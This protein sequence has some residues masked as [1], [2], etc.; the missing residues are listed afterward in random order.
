MKS[1]TGLSLLFFLASFQLSL[2]AEPGVE[3]EKDRVT[4]QNGDAIRAVIVPSMGGELSGLSMRFDGD[5]HELLYRALDYEKRPGWRGKAPLLWPATGISVIKKSGEAGYLLDG[6]PYDMP[7]HGFARSSSWQV[8]GTE[9]TTEFA[10]LTL[11]LHDDANTRRFYPFGF[12]LQVEYRLDNEKLRLLYRVDADPGNDRDMPFSIGNHI[13]FR[14][15]LIPGS[16]PGDLRFENELPDLLL[17]GEDKAFSG[18]VEPSPYTG[19]H[20]LAS[21]PHRQAVSLGIDSSVARFTMNDPSGLSLELVQ[22]SQWL[23][24]GPLIRFNLWADMEE[25]FFSPEPW[26]GTQNSLNTGAGLLQLRPGQ[27][28]EWTID[29]IPF[30]GEPIK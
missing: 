15:P 20:R 26:V 30:T 12:T 4:L 5:W 2:A 9:Q 29:I 13:T 23:P 25:G 7:F 17:R 21:L 10:A 18:V 8:V 27:S 1:S 19:T 22:K 6:L 24:S 3:I 16:N 11:A 28:W 14:I